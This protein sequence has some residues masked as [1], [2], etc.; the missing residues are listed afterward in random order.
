MEDN[1]QL[2]SPSEVIEAPPTPP[3]STLDADTLSEVT[4]MLLD[5]SVDGDRRPEDVSRS[6]LLLMPDR[7]DDLSKDTV[8]WGAEVEVLFIILASDSLHLRSREETQ[9]MKALT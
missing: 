1:S 9:R 6:T 7:E 8:F 4:D 2:V 5:N 3:M